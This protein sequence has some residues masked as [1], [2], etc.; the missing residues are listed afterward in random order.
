MSTPG[1]PDNRETE[2]EDQRTPTREG[3]PPH[4]A[5]SAGIATANASFH[6]FKDRI[7]NTSNS[8]LLVRN[9]DIRPAPLPGGTAL[10]AIGNVR[11]AGSI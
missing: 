6:D 8:P 10:P 1:R 11:I 9:E 2:T 4:P 3:E 5:T 7:R